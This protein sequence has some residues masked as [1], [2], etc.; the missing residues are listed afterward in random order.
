MWV[1]E[2]DVEALGETESS[3]EDIVGEVA[4]VME[5]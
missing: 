5:L 3:L 4:V 2:R 1:E